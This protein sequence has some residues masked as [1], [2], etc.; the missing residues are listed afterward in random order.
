MAFVIFACVMLCIYVRPFGLPIWLISTMGAALSLGVGSVTLGDVAFVW[1]MVWDSALTLVGLMVFALCLEKLGFFEMLAYWIVK[2]SQSKHGLETWKFYCFMGLFASFLAAFFANDGAILILTPLVIA[3]LVHVKNIKF[4]RN[5]CIVFLLFAGFMSDFASNV[6][7]FSNLT[8]IITAEFFSIGFLEFFLMM[9]FPQLFVVIFMLVVFWCVFA[10]KLPKTLEFNLNP[11]ALPKPSIT[12]FCVSLIALL[13]VGIVSMDGLGIPLSVFTLSVALLSLLCGIL[14]QKFQVKQ[15]LKEAPFGIV[16]FSLGL[17][18]VVFGL[19]N[20]GIVESLKQGLE[21]FDTLP[22][23]LGIFG[24][25]IASSLGSSVMNNLPMVML[26]DLVLVDSQKELIFA[27]L[28]GCNIGAKLT[29]IGSLAT[30]LW[31]FSLRRYGITIGFLQYTSIALL[32]TFPVLSVGLFGLY[33]GRIL[34]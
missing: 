32:L 12:L 23:L 22:S 29:P 21:F 24:V 5:P 34:T 31:L 14:T 7:V 28:L 26:G 16:V 17:F 9:L 27:H 6:F 18:V 1:N 30:L 8:N 19:N 11:N 13:L 4:S 25:G 10:H 3:L 20:I 15:I 33:V 2:F